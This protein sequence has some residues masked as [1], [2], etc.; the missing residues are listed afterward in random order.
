MKRR[1]YSMRDLI[2][3]FQNNLRRT[4]II[5]IILLVVSVSVSFGLSRMYTETDVDRDDTRVPFISLQ[6][7]KNDET[8]FYKTNFELKKMTDALNAYVEYL[9]QVDLNGTNREKLVDFQNELYVNQDFFDEVIG[10][11]NHNT[12]I[13][14]ENLEAAEGFVDQHINELEDAIARI[15]KQ[16]EEYDE[17]TFASKSYISE[18]QKDLFSQKSTYEEELSVWDR[19]EQNLQGIDDEKISYVNRQ[20]EELLEQGVEIYNNLVEEFNQMIVSFEDEQYDIIYN[21]YILDTYGSDEQYDIIYNPYILDTYGSIAGLTS[22]FEEE[23]IMN[24]NKNSA[25]IYAKSVAGLDSREERF[26]SYLTFGV[27]FSVVILALYGMF[28]K[29]GISENSK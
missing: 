17:Y 28:T 12:P 2:D 14:I 10:Y 18:K 5:F 25:L 19:Q 16:L 11:Y 1:E 21:P 4:G 23:E 6:Q 7:F 15:D 22:E 20:M 9:F 27:L 8:F 13:Y 29:R 24:V 26:F 3:N